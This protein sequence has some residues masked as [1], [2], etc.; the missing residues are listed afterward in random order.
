MEVN[1]V[2]FQEK[3]TQSTNNV[4]KALL[5]LEKEMYYAN[6]S[7][8]ISFIGGSCK[9]CKNGCNEKRCVNPELS[10]MPLEATGC[11]V[12]ESL[13]KV[14]IDVTFPITDTLYRY[15]LLLW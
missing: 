3:R 1:S 10:R 2:N 8:A 15:G 11:N 7:L 6:H 5:Y 9:L 4:H 14:D 13:K 12:V